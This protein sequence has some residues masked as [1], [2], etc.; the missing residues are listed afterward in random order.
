MRGPDIV[1]QMLGSGLTQRMKEVSR[2]SEEAKAIIAGT[3][4][5]I[6][7]A[8]PDEEWEQIMAAAKMPCG[9]PDCDC[10]IYGEKM[11]DGL[12]AGREHHKRVMAKWDK[13][14]KR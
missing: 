2:N 14:A 1:L 9:L 8:W 11:F 10:E 4:A 3:L 12:N 5:S 13:A 6:I 7:A